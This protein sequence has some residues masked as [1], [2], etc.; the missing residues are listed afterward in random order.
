MPWSVHDR[1][2]E[3][4]IARQLVDRYLSCWNESDDDARCV[5]V[6]GTWIEGGRS[7]DP[8]ADVAGHDEISSMMGSVQAQMPGHRFGLVGDVHAHHDVVH[9]SW[10]MSDPSGV[11]VIAGVDTAMVADGRIS[12]LAGFFLS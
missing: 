6:S 9:W 4:D 10:A 2:M 8:L 5:L 7:V 1:I 11:T 3:L 12:A